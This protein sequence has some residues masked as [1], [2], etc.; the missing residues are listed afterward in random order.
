MSTD[1]PVALITGAAKRVG[2]VI[3]RRLHAA[4]F[5]LALHHRG[6]AD[7][8]ATLVAGLEAARAGSTLV[9]QAEL[10][11]PAAPAALVQAV[12]ARFGRLDALVNNASSFRPT[13]VGE[14]TPADWDDLFASNARAP[15]FLAQAAAP[16]LRQA[17]GAIVNLGDIYG[18]RPLPAHTIYCMAKAALLMM[19]RSLA[20]E[21]GPE[22]R[23][24]AVA[25]GAVMWP[26]EG[27]AE[28]EKQAMLANT[29]LGRAGEPDDV[30][31]A[32]RWLV[33]DAR[34]TT[35]EVIRVDGGRSVNM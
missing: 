27:K 4:G 20:R 34:Y 18:E 9:L 5:D 30:A 21:L 6:S 29:A 11:D 35:G 26:E 12:Q 13:P 17:G 14:A 23:V 25:P 32:V 31:E 28:H 8:M 10:A 7:A 22:V 33:Q 1:R 15:F 3:A 2:A 19:T 16:L 24:N